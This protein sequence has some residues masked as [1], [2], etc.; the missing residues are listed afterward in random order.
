MRQRVVAN[1][2]GTVYR[3]LDETS[4]W[5][6]DL[7]DPIPAALV[8]AAL[9]RRDVLT[10]LSTALANNQAYLASGTPTVAQVAAQ[11]RALTRQMNAL[12]RIVGDHLDDISDT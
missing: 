6:A 5:D 2:D 7:E 10:K 12:L 4:S 8:T 3:L 11:V 9:N 1:P